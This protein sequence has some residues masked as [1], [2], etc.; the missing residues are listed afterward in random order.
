M[1]CD[2][3][4]AGRVKACKN[5]QGGLF[6]LY[7]YEWVK[8]SLVLAGETMA[9]TG[10]ISPFPD[11]YQ[12]E[13]EG[14]VNTF[15]AEKVSDRNTGAT[16]VTQ[17]LTFAL[18]GIDLE[19]TAVLNALS[20]GYYCAVISDRNGVNHCGGLDDGFD[21]TVTEVTGGAKADM[22][23]YNIVGVATTKL[24][25]PKIESTQFTSFLTNVVAPV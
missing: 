25:P 15:V 16:V 22:N 2:T 18:K 5:S 20:Q 7:I 13:I 14:D 10:L 19:T 21:F 24:M 3:I 6:T 11:V 4:T 1:A 9:V 12:F 17:T 23:G 8:D